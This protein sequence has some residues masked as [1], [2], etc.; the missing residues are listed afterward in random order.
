[1]FIVAKLLVL[2]FERAAK[3]SPQEV[4]QCLR[5]FLNGAGGDWDW[6]DFISIPIADPRLEAIRARAADL[7]LPVADTDIDTLKALVAE[8]ERLAETT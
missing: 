7:D 8:A 3:R 4:A 2:P 5:D 6:D 1:M